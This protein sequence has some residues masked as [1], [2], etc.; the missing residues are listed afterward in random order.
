MHTPDVNGEYT[1]GSGDHEYLF[2]EQFW[3]NGAGVSDLLRPGLKSTNPG[4]IVVNW[5]K[6][7]FDPFFRGISC[8][9]WEVICLT[10]AHLAKRQIL[11]HISN[12]KISC[13]SFIWLL[14]TLP[15]NPSKLRPGTIGVSF[16]RW[17]EHIFQLCVFWWFWHT[18]DYWPLCC[19]F[20]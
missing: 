20:I 5:S 13:E 1:G 16:A 9:L 2:F 4:Q 10:A 11:W 18:K 8:T 7:D 15:T 14:L 12:L 6:L 17:L 3:S 19:L